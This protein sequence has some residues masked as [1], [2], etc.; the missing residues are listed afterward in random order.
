MKGVIMTTIKVQTEQWEEH[1]FTIE[2]TITIDDKATGT[3]YLH[4][5]RVAMLIEGY[6]NEVIRNACQ[7]IEYEMEETIESCFKV[8]NDRK[9]K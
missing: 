8:M 4:A 7:E 3:E 2:A 5:C 6:S 9:E 1:P